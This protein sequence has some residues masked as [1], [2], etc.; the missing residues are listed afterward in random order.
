MAGEGLECYTDSKINEDIAKLKDEPPCKNII[1]FRNEYI[2]HFGKVRNIAPKYEELYEA[3][4]IIEKIA[5]KY[6]LIINGAH[7]KLAPTMQGDWE[8]VF[9]VPWIEKVEQAP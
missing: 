3:F 1:L 6:N 8:E 5:K 2:A 4:K 9:T 7:I